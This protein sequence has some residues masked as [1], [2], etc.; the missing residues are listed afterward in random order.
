MI[1][2]INGNYYADRSVADAI[3]DRVISE[4]GADNKRV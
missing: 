2:F 4:L 1:A 3:A